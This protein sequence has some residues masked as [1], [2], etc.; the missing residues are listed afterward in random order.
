M[1]NFEIRYELDCSGQ[2][3]EKSVWVKG[4]DEQSAQDYLVNQIDQQYDDCTLLEM[5]VVATRED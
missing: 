3:I 5:E 1:K 2:T 4:T